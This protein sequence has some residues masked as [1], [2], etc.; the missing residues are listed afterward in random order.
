[1]REAKSREDLGNYSEYGMY[2][3]IVDRKNSDGVS[4]SVDRY[5]KRGMQLPSPRWTRSF[6]LSGGSFDSCGSWGITPARGIELETFGIPAEFAGKMLALLGRADYDFYHVVEVYN[7]GVVPQKRSEFHACVRG[8]ERQTVSQ[9]A[10]A[11][12]GKSTMRLG[13]M[14]GGQFFGY[15][16]KN[17]TRV[18]S[19]TSYNS[20]NGIYVFDY[21]GESATS[22]SDISNS[23]FQ[24]WLAKRPS[25]NEMERRQHEKEPTRPVGWLEKVPPRLMAVAVRQNKK[26][27]NG[28]NLQH[29]RT[30][31]G[32]VF[33]CGDGETLIH[34][35]NYD[36]E[37]CKTVLGRK[38]RTDL[39][40]AKVM[41][42]WFVWNPLIGFQ[43]HI[44][45]T[46]FKEAINMWE[47]RS[48]RG[49]PRPLCLN[50]VRNDRNGTAGFCLVGTKAFLQNRMPF[51]Y[52]LVSE[53]SSWSEIPDEIMSIKWDVEFRIFAGYP[54]P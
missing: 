17:S 28:Y 21:N 11:I 22:Y 19:G 45:S 53:Y 31:I 37:S 23:I 2:S 49:E 29:S 47:N 51:V 42:V 46:S 6:V 34:S 26:Y 7:E 40:V 54:V 35:E 44:E 33:D 38:I 20:F 50:E 41:G 14:S 4:E 32:H 8:I 10:C 16:I 48:R 5:L 13:W 36:N 15:I 24:R 27:L 3:E 9:S 52:N 18:G 12:P 43:N 1:M 25:K 30:S 39:S